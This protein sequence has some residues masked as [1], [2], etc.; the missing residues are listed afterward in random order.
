LG[1]KQKENYL[2]TLA[3]VP[4][5]LHGDI[6]RL[7]SFLWW[8]EEFKDISTR[9]YYI[10]RR[11]SLALGL[12][13]EKE[14]SLESADDIFF[15]S[16]SDIEAKNTGQAAQNKR[17]YRSFINFHN[18]NE[19]GSRYITI[20]EQVNGSQILKGVP[21]SG[22]SVT[23]AACVVKDIHDCDRL[24]QGD[25]LVTRCTDPAW[26]AVFSKIGGVITETGGMLSHAA[27]VSREYGLPCILLA[28]N[29]VDII[30]D[31]DLITMDCTTGEI[32]R[33]QDV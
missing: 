6:D 23:A 28:K 31:G 33:S 32:Y 7:R 9:S 14:G 22:E 25:I 13:W 21:C 20:K 15:L 12:A 16:V 8:R 18:P 30:R 29:A 4:K 26:T 10:I 17:Y 19:L 3:K 5:R 27:V 1:E 11:L 2:R 24:H